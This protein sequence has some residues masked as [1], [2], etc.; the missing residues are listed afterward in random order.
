MAVRVRAVCPRG[1][2]EPSGANPAPLRLPQTL[3]PV[4]DLGRALASSQQASLA[5][6][7]QVEIL[8]KTNAQLKVL[9]GQREHAVAP[10]ASRHLTWKSMDLFSSAEL[11]PNAT[12]EIKRFLTQRSCFRKDD[13][14]FRVG[15]KSYALYAI[16]IGS[17]KTVLLAND[18]QDQ[19]AGFHMAGEIIGVD[20]IATDIHE[21]E[22]IALEEMEVC[23][24]PLDQIERLAFG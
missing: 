18:G 14:P 10:S 12:P 22:A 8:T 23:R 16:R 7:H 4:K 6:Q 20:G 17:C 9:A 5:S 15:D 24:L 19:V 21:C 1:A 3:A 11:D 13:V 2:V